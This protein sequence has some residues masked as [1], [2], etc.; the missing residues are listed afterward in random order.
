[1]C[2]W[3][4]EKEKV[5]QLSVWQL[6]GKDAIGTDLHPSDLAVLPLITY[7]AV[8]VLSVHKQTFTG[9]KFTEYLNGIMSRKLERYCFLMLGSKEDIRQMGMSS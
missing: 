7:N 2:L 3:V 4:A 6:M 8:T 1:M 5:R 9:T